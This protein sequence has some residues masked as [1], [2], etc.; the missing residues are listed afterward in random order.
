MTGFPLGVPPLRADGLWVEPRAG[1]QPPGGRGGNDRRA[2]LFLD[3]DGVLVEEVHYLHRPEDVRLVPGAAAVVGAAKARG[4]AVVLVT[5]QAGIGR[6]YYG[7]S[8][9]AAT[10]AAIYAALAAEGAPAGG[11]FDLVL[12]CP[13]HPEGQPPYRHADPPCR[14]PNPGMLREAL[15]RLAL[16]PAASLMVGDRA[17]DLQAARAAGLRRGLI[18][19]T[20][21]GADAREQAAALALAAA[22]FR[23]D[24]IPSIAAVATLL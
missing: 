17:I 6:G 11:G 14:K 3:R 12:A 18:V 10:Q 23:V 5:N 9:F 16:D 13:H 22:D 8:A 20:G 2:A 7:W 15:E 24:Q 21:H 1:G 4:W 19:A